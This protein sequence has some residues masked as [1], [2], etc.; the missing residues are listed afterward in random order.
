MASLPGLRLQWICITRVLRVPGFR[1]LWLKDLCDL[2]RI[3]VDMEWMFLGGIQIGDLPFFCG[4]QKHRLVDCVVLELFAVDFQCRNIV[5]KNQ[6]T[7][8]KYIA[9]WNVRDRKSTR[10]NSS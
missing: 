1:A 6:I 10:L 9:L 3:Y 8:H 5:M 7:S 4:I 2:E